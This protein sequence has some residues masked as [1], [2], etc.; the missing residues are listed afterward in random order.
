[1]L[2]GKN[3]VFNMASEKRRKKMRNARLTGG[4]GK[5]LKE[6]QM[7]FCSIRLRRKKSGKHNQRLSYS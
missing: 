3:L 1:L 6:K 7:T 5:A 4:A 2:S